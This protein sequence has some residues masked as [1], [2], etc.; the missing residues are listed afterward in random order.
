M[1]QAEIQELK[2]SII[3]HKVRFGIGGETEEKARALYLLRKHHKNI[4]DLHWITLRLVIDSGYF[5]YNPK[6]PVVL[7]LN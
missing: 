2:D 3:N 1:I 6:A 4:F 5:I 7:S